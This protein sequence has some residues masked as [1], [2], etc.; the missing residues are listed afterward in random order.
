MRNR[1]TIYCK[2]KAGNEIIET[3]TYYTQP[4]NNN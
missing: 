3:Q 1:I 4:E 2:D